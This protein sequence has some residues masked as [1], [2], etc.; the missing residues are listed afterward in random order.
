VRDHL[1]DVAS[2]AVLLRQRDEGPAQIVTSSATH[3]E[4]LQIL[5]EGLVRFVGA[6]QRPFVVVVRVHFVVVKHS[7]D[8]SRHDDVFG[9]RC[10]VPTWR[11]AVRVSTLGE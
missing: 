2:R 8:G 5:Q 6:P 3:T 10:T 1:E 4:R 11:G 7:P 9:N